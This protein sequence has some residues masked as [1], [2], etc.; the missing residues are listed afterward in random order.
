[1]TKRRPDDGCCAQARALGHLDR[2][3]G[4]FGAE[5]PIIMTGGA[6][7]SLL[8]Q[9]FHLSSAERRTLLASGA[10]AGM[11]AIFAA[12]FAAVLLAIELLLFEWKPRSFI[13]VALAAA[14]AAAL[15][16]PLLGTP[17]IFPVAIH[18][19]VG[20][21]TLAFAILVGAVAGLASGAVTSL[22]YRFEDV[23]RKIPVHW[24]WWPA[25]GGLGVGL[26]GWVDPRILGVGHDIIHQVLRGEL[27]GAAL[28]G[29]V[30]KA[31][32]WSFALDSGISGGV[33]APLLMMGSVLGAVAARW[34]P[35]G[36]SA[37][38]AW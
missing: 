28:L 2:H 8:G 6:L 36:D 27:V 33:L 15:R 19:P 32:A 25:I 21:D 22:V 37:M 31:L 38:W 4:P 1:M 17:P 7:G 10:A 26:I 35:V 14:V 29:L 12:P 11:A 3:G 24:M 16:E 18:L 9:F 23:F 34:I 5:G 20:M 30:T 13:P